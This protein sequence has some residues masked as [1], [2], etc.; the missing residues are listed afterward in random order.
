MAQTAGPVASGVASEIAGLPFALNGH[1]EDREAAERVIAST[2]RHDTARTDGVMAR[3]FDRRISWHLSY[4]L[5]NTAVTPNQVTIAN[6]AFGMFIAWMFAQP[7]YWLPLLASLMFVVSITLDGVDGELARLKMAETAAGARLDA[8]TDNL[9]HIA[10]FLGIGIGCYRAGHNPAYI[11]NLFLQAAR[12]DS[13]MRHFG[14]SRDERFRGRG[15]S[16]HQ[17]SRPHDRPRFRVPGFLFS[18]H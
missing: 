12:P 16:V 15:R 13:A 8:L 6:T 3:I 4:R 9:V 7:G 11:Y 17:E 5:A 1:P 10:I 14:P 18:T 2:L